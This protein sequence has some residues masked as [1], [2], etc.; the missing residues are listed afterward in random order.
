GAVSAAYEMPV[1]DG[2]ARFFVEF[3][4]SAD[5]YLT[6]LDNAP[7]T[8]VQEM[9]LVNANVEWSPD[10]GNWTVSLWGRNLEDKRYIS[11]VFEAVGTIRMVNYANPREVGLTVNYRW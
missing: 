1:A 11:S 8:R 10:N 9:N 6:S 7:T 5:K 4:H 2:M 3:T